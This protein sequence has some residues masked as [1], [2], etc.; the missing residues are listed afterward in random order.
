M[1]KINQILKTVKDFVI[2]HKS[3]IIYLLASIIV[4]YL[5]SGQRKIYLKH[6]LEVNVELDSNVV[7]DGMYIQ[8]EPDSIIIEKLDS[9]LM[10]YD[11]EN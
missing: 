6:N 9:A 3:V 7:R 5:F 2:K 11:N 10:M 8:Q 1:Q 4:A